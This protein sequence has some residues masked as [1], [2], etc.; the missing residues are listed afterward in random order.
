MRGTT[1]CCATLAINFILSGLTQAGW[2]KIEL[3][4]SDTI[5]KIILVY[6]RLRRDSVGADF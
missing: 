3:I 5:R 1:T 2:R 6:S 4:R